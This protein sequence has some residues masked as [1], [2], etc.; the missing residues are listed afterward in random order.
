M[1][2]SLLG[3][4]IGDLDVAVGE[5]IVDGVRVWPL[6]MHIRTRGVASAMLKVDDTFE[7]HFDPV[8]GLSVSSV[9]VE[10]SGKYHNRETVRIAEGTAF[11]HDDGTHGSRDRT[12]AVPLGSTDI[13]AALFSLRNMSFGDATV[14]VPIF[15][16]WKSWDMEVTVA[17]HER[18]RVE[19]GT[20]DT[21]ILHC[22]IHFTGKFASDRGLTI[23]VSDDARR[24]PVQM[25][26]PF[27][28][29]TMRVRLA[30]WGDSP[31][32]GK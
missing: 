15:T 7:S 29:G 11:V 14:H 9:F 22:V 4:H 13:L 16:G 18:M 28:I 21:L 31:Q 30:S 6:D 2:V 26:A 1:T 23:W 19:A 3:V 27:S 32:A 12:E 10:T 5:G 25:E 17:G 8:T 24:L 20:F